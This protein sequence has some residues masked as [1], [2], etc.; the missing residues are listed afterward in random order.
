MNWIWHLRYWFYRSGGAVQRLFRVFPK[1]F[2]TVG[3]V[4]AGL[5]RDPEMRKLLDDAREKTGITRRIW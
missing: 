3:E 5:E 1:D 2:R 4:M